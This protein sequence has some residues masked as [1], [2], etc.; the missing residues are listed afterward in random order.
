[1]ATSHIKNETSGLNEKVVKV[2]V[3]LAYGILYARIKRGKYAIDFSILFVVVV[4]V[5]VIIKPV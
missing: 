1:M 3:K 5:N 4:V 2:E